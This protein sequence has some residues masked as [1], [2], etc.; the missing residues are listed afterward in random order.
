[1]VTLRPS[2]LEI[3]ATVESPLIVVH[4]KIRGASVLHV[5]DEVDLSTAHE[6]EAE[7]NLL[8]GADRCVV[9]LSECRY[10]DTS[11]ITVLIRAFRR[12]GNQLRIVVPLRSHIE[13]IFGLAGL[14][15]V[16][17]I[18]PTL[19]RALAVDGAQPAN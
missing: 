3:P 9:D 12:L 19:D 18:V 1:M 4:D 10:I 14:H 7:V 2:T 11:T 6:L 5:F 8:L 16:L 17:P 13:R 15:D